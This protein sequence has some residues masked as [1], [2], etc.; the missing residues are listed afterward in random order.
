MDHHSDHSRG[1][2]EEEIRGNLWG[3]L[4]HRL[5]HRHHH[6]TGSTVADFG[7]EGI[8]ATKVSLAALGVTALLQALIVVASG[9][10]ALL[11]DTI[12]NLGDALTAIPLW[13]AF[14]L[15]RRRPS[16]TFTHGLSRAE[17]LAGLLIVLSI[18]AS[19]V[20]VGWESVRR[21]VEP[22]LIEQ[23]PWVI[24]AGVLGAAGNEV[25]ARYRIRVGRRIGSAALIADGRHARSDAWTSLAV[26]AAGIG[27][28]FGFT[29]VDPVAG[30]VVAG[31]ITGLLVPSIR[32]IGRRLLDGVDPD[33]VIEAEAVIRSVAGVQGVSELRL[34]FQG[35][36]LDLTTCIQ[37]DP[38]LS[39]A[40]A[41]DTAHAVEH[42]LHHALGVP[43]SATVHVEPHGVDD[44]H[45]SIAHHR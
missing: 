36:R 45:R 40:R 5:A 16:R 37:V 42:E 35:H 4:R 25:V 21:L 28:A 6:E 10:V 39:L 26:V 14:A 11:S 2:G 31:V 33:L 32:D 20:L 15:G 7:A 23:I 27:A 43:M 12:H 24:A 1:S 34:R 17:D 29:W 9:S 30:L 44:A 18:G 8:R 22:R 3:W 41:H 38:G 19:A 13:I